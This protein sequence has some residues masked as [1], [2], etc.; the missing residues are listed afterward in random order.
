MKSIHQ[1]QTLK[2]P[3][4]AFTV[5][6]TSSIPISVN[7][8]LAEELQS[9]IDIREANEITQWQSPETDL[10]DVAGRLIDLKGGREII[11]N[12]GNRNTIVTDGNHFRRIHQPGRGFGNYLSGGYGA[13]R[14]RPLPDAW[15]IPMAEQMHREIDHYGGGGDWRNW[16][17]NPNKMYNDY[18]NF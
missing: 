6:F 3:L 12:G 9:N 1:Q 2:R 10:G 16:E 15:K 4:I 8:Q 7:A 17:R 18:L 5:L 13:E 11:R 14:V